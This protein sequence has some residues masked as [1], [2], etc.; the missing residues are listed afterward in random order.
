MP[1]VLTTIVGAAAT[2]LLCLISSCPCST[3]EQLTRQVCWAQVVPGELITIMGVAAPWLLCSVVTLCLNPCMWK[4]C[5]EAVLHAGG[6][7]GADHHHRSAQLWQ[8]RVDRCP[9][10]QLVG[11]VWLAL[12]ALL[13]GE[14]GTTCSALHLA[15]GESCQ[16]GGT[17]MLH[18]WWQTITRTVPKAS[19]STR[20][21]LH[22]L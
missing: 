14:E 16:A 13:H 5:Q 9:H 20:C 19:G 7:W 8:V 2:R 11:P 18:M 21:K 12:W 3:L 15:M 1:G 4:S 6:A 22:E 17:V 10:G